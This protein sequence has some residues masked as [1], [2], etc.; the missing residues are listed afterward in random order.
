MPGTDEQQMDG[1]QTLAQRRFWPRR[2]RTRISG[3]VAVLALIGG[4]AVWLQREQIASDV[5]DDFLTTNGV[6]ATYDIVAIGPQVQV[7]ENMVVGNPARPD[8]T[9]QRM[10]VELGVGWAG[11]QVRRVTIIGARAYGS[12]RGGIF[13]LGALDPLIFT[14]SA[15]PPALPAINVTLRDARA[16]VESDFGAI[17][18]SLEGSGWLDDGFAGALA[19]TA[20][21]IGVDG[22]WAE[23]ATLYGT[24]TT[25]DG[26][27]RVEGPLRISDLTCGGAAVKRADIGTA[28][29]LK[30]DF[31]GAEGD[32]RFEGSE[33]TYQTAVAEAFSG[34]A[35]LTWGDSGLALAHD[36][37]LT[38]VRAPQGRLARLSA[39]GAWRGTANASRGQWEGQLRGAGLIPGADLNASL[40]VAERGLDGTLLA[41]L[42]AKARSGL[43]RALTGASFTADDI[44]RHKG[45]DIALIIP[46]AAI[47]S[48]AG[49]RVLALSQVSAGLGSDGLTGMRGNILA[50]GEGLPSI[51]GRME[52]EPGG[53]WA[54]R[55]AMADYAAD[56]NRLAIPRLALRQTRGGGI[57]FEGLITASGALPG[58]A[59]NDLTLPLEGA[60]SPNSRL[61]M[62]SRCLPL[63]FASLSLSGLALKGQAITLCPERG[64]PMLVYDNGIVLAASTGPV[65][66]SGTL[67]DNPTTL[68]ADA[69]RLRYPAPSAV[70][71]LAARIGAPGNEVRLSAA[72]L[73]G[74]LAG[75]VA[76][77]FTGGAARMDI[78]PLDLAG[79]TGRWSFSDGVLRIA[80]GAFT[81]TD[82]P[83]PGPA[84]VLPRFSPLIASGASLRLADNIITADAALRHPASARAVA[85]VVISHDLNTSTGRAR[86]AVP[87]IVFDQ[88]LQPEDL[89]YLAKG[90]IAFADGTVAGTGRINWSADA[91]TS[92]GSFSSEG[93]DFAAAFGPV[94]GLKGKVD[95][96]DLLNLT[97]APD[98]T[99]SISAIN[100]G[101]EVLDGTVQFEVKDGTLLT[102][103]DARF[104]FMGGELRMRPLAMDFSQPEERRYVFEII[105]LDAATFVAQMELT[106]LGATGTFDGTV[107]IIF[108]KDGNGR[109]EGGLLLSRTPGGNVA[110]I[111]ELTYEDL[112]TMGN[113][114]FSALRSLDYKQMSVGLNGNLAGEIITNFQFDGVQ[115][116]A[117]T[118]QNFVTRRLAKLPIRFK[119][120]VRAQNF[121]ELTTMVRSFWDVGFLGNPVDR[122][123]LRTEGGQFVPVRPAVQPILPLDNELVQPPESEDQP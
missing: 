57:G 121:Y 63:R 114:A 75:D 70:E 17:G 16:V 23:R 86:L 15:E 92:S 71:G 76:G 8:V 31:N 9:V 95:F 83:M 87:G 78:M 103:E 45:A 106:N 120:N 34:T 6:P 27:P 112:G 21:G 79:I 49:T 65:S 55:L 73:T 67:G 90:V 20:P 43:T 96:T 66:L 30:R 111:G 115:Q 81:L 118:S 39:E 104:P 100:P 44:I 37:A 10:V 4:S 117:G 109:I 5:I 42:V 26:A 119:I 68:S 64:G 58:G 101:I 72:R 93:I 51:N 22:C 33:A 36:L 85:E 35:R 11:P 59:V 110:Y 62:G 98:Q 3:G 102:L 77:E 91:I 94:R 82:R 13:S 84:P 18:V 105:G 14:D 69:L 108:D 53:N 80:D 113:Y 54:L 25:A 32:F 48:R 99:V 60:W 116:G 12:Y 47:S 46:E 40:A 2:W 107:P 56:A 1:P 38:D 97:T 61:A 24:L 89:S 122:G 7:I 50:G 28:L 29:T 41:P 123:L 74:S 19:A 52:Q 88:N